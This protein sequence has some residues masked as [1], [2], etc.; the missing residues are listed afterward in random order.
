VNL[1]EFLA[2]VR[3]N[4]F[5]ETKD[6]FPDTP[7]DDHSHTLARYINMAAQHVANIADAMDQGLFVREVTATIPPEEGGA[8]SYIVRIPFSD[9]GIDDIY[10]F[11]RVILLIRENVEGGDDIYEPAT[12]QSINF[13]DLDKYAAGADSSEE[14]PKYAIAEQAV[15]LVRPTVDIQLRMFY[16]CS[17]P[18]H[19]MQ[20]LGDHP[21]GDTP[22]MHNGNGVPNA[23]PVE[24]HALVAVKATLL[25]LAASNASIEPWAGIYANLLNELQATLTKRRGARTGTAT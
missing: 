1:K 17:L 14:L 6:R 25:A 24:Y 22:G 4:V 11:R 18:E 7:G 15:Y 21:N 5:D 8:A 9:F 13:E 23:L 10:P 3:A 16:V 20:S 12:L 19:G 2:T